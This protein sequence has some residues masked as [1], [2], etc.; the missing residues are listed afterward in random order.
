MAPKI[1]PILAHKKAYEIGKFHNLTAGD[2]DSID[3]I[4]C[5]STTIDQFTCGLLND[6]TTCHEA[7]GSDEEIKNI[8]HG[9][10]NQWWIDQEVAKNDQ[11]S[12]VDSV[13]S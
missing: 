8:V 2:M 5:A 4:Y 7:G 13:N 3:D 9:Y 6:L 11:Q 10:A 12:Q 1:S